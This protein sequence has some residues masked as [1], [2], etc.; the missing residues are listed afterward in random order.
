MDLSKL[1]LQELD[2]LFKHSER[3]AEKYAACIKDCEGYPEDNYDYQ[4]YCL[5]TEKFVALCNP[6]TNGSMTLEAITHLADRKYKLKPS[7]CR[8]ERMR[9]REQKR[10]YI[11]R[12]MKEY[13]LT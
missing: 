3:T 13:K 8:L 11:E 4:R 5:L 6:Q 2:I 9:K 12:M 7:D 1:S 10:L